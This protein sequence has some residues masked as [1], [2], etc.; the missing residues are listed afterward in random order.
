MIVEGVAI[1]LGR[2]PVR[3]GSHLGLTRT[4]AIVLVDTRTERWVFSGG[5]YR[6]GRRIEVQVPPDFRVHGQQVKVR[7]PDTSP[8]ADELSRVASIDPSSA[9]ISQVSFIPHLVEE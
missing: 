5:K 3:V 4:F 6:G 2:V 7:V 9:S 8:Y 1:G